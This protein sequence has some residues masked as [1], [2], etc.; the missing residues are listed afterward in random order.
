MKS[1]SDTSR[2]QSSAMS[3]HGPGRGWLRRRPLRQRVLGV[4]VALVVPALGVGVAA[5]GGARSWLVTQRAT[6]ARS[7]ACIAERLIGATGSLQTIAVHAPS[8]F[9]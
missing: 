9:F 2:D 5:C 6:T 4:A 3:Q 1:Y 7:A 8:P